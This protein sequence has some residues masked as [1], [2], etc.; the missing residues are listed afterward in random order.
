MQPQLAWPAVRCS[1]A[2]LQEEERALVAILAQPTEAAQ[3]LLA[4]RPQP[5]G[6]GRRLAC[7]GRP[8]RAARRGR[9]ARWGRSR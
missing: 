8:G 9:A 4:Q 7:P 2:C 5:Q 3:R 1:G 6:R